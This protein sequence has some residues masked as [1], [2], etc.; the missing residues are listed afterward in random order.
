M[1]IRNDVVRYSSQHTFHLTPYFRFF[2][3]RNRKGSGLFIEAN[4]S[5]FYNFSSGT[6]QYPV[7]SGWQPGPGGGTILT[8]RTVRYEFSD[9]VFGYGFGLGLG[10]KFLN[11]NN[12]V[13]ELMI[14]GG[15]HSCYFRQTHLRFSASVGRRF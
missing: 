2:F 3:D 7:Q 13:G 12:W 15:Y 8:W 11:E 1:Y 14:G 4:G 5:V 10:W 9:H 6:V